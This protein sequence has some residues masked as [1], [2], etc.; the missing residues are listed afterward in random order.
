MSSLGKSNPFLYQ[1]SKSFAPLV[2]I[3]I[4]QNLNYEARG[5]DFNDFP[6]GRVDVTSFC[7]GVEF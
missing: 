7:I 6:K 1:L 4:G 2:T 5:Q 3:L